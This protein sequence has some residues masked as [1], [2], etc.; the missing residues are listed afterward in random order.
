MNV[1]TVEPLIATYL[2]DKA[3][4]NKIPLSGTFELSP[5]CNMDCKMCY[6]KM[7]KSEVDKV[8]RLRTV[9]EWISIAEEAKDAGMLFLL[10]TGGEPLLYKG[11]KELYLKL[12]KMGLII[13]INTNAT[14]IDE[15]MADSLQ[16][17]HHQD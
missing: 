8:G 1:K 10:I 16:N 4:K 13:S 11:F 3:V 15:E 5:I 12:V 7:T 14:L 9:E 2:S 6:V 17:I